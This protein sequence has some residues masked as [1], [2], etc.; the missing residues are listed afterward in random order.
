MTYTFT[1]TG[2]HCGSCGMLVDE[3]LEELPG[4]RASRTDVRH[5]TTTVDHDDVIDPAT[6]TAA[7][8]ELGYRATLAS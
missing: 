4:V 2:M 6:I 8:A 7:I 5:R 3:T 1:V